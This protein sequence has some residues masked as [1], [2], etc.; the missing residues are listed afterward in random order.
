MAKNEG[1]CKV[2]ATN[3]GDWLDNVPD[4]RT[5]TGKGMASVLEN[6]CVTFAE[7]AEAYDLK[8]WNK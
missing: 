3:P 6:Q 5:G 8:E 2:F 4:E 7:L 1:L